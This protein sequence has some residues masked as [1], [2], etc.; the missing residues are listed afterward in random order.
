MGGGAGGFV[1]GRGGIGEGGAFFFL[2]KKTF[3]K[4]EST[5]RGRGWRFI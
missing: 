5:L 3:V 4:K 1:G 2:K